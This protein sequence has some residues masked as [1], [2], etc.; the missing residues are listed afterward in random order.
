LAAI[1]QKSFRRRIIRFAGDIWRALHKSNLS[2]QIRL[3]LGDP[4]DTGRLWAVVGPVA[5]ILSNTR[6]ASIEVMPEFLESTF[7]MGGSGEIRVI[8]LQMIYLTA[9]L[10]L[11]PPFWQGIRRMRAVDR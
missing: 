11:S 7:E 8:P 2:L 1:R 10:L 3:G 6:E 9:G 5:G 4:A